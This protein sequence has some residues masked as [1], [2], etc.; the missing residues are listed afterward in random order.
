VA[1]TV[2]GWL[3][4]QQRRR[5][6]ASRWRLVVR[7]A[8]IFTPGPAF[9]VTGVGMLP[10]FPTRVWRPDE[11]GWLGVVDDRRAGE[12]WE[13]D[14][15]VVEAITVAEAVAM[16]AGD[17]DPAPLTTG[18]AAEQLGISRSAIDLLAAQLP[19]ERYGVAWRGG[20]GGQRAHRRWDPELLRLWAAEA[21]AIEQPKTAPPRRR[22]RRKPAP[23]ED[24]PSGRLDAGGPGGRARR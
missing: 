11:P 15:G 18:Q 6:G 20:T 1:A 13:S 12:S 2:L 4:Q 8:V 7:V 23:E 3:L 17:G 16:I 22:R 14:C 19:P 10:G 24:A 21:S 5:I 9:F